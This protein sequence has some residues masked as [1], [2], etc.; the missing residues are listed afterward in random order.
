VDAPPIALQLYTVR[1]E[2][3]RSLPDTLRKV[4]ALGYSAVEFAGYGNL[5]AQAL[6]ALLD[7]L[8][9]RAPAS[10]C[11]SLDI[12]PDDLAQKLAYAKTIS[13]EYMV[14][15]SI[16]P[17]R[18]TEALLPALTKQLEALGQRCREAGFQFVYHTHDYS[19]R[20]RG[21]AYLLD[22]LLDAI[23]PTLLAIELDVYWL[24]FAGH[25]PLTYLREH[26]SRIPLLHL[27]D[28]GASREMTEVGDGTLDMPALISA[29]QSSGTRWLIVEHDR[30]TL[31]SL[32]SAR[33]SLD[34]LNSLITWHA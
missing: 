4:A 3:A 28:M 2:T 9:L 20:Q 34:Y 19:F 31:P 24:A 13:C 33:R 17:Q 10:H 6:R 27:K 23:D 5:S 32:E 1:D 14:L 29:A 12:A 22:E 16:G 21:D 11:L 30:P 15:P 18:F 25:D 26:G 7:E 8:G